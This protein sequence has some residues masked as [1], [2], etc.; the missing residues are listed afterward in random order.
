MNWKIGRNDPCPCGSGKKFKKCCGL[1]SDTALV[2]PFERYN[3][4]LTALKLKLDQHFSSSIKRL[5][6]D[7]M[8][9]FLHHTVNRTLPP[10]HEPLYSD[11]LWFDR[12]APEQ[13]S[14]AEQYLQENGPFMETPLRDCL[15]AL[16]DSSLSIYRVEDARDMLLEVSDLFSG[17][18]IEVL[19]KEPWQG[20]PDR[21]I[22]ILGRLVKVYED[23]LFS[24]M[25]LL[26]EDNAGQE[27]FLLAHY[28]YLQ[29]L[30]LFPDG[31]P[32]EVKYGLF[33]HAHKKKLFNLRDMRMTMID[34]DGIGL[35]MNRFA[36]Q[37]E[38]YLLHHTDQV[39]WYAPRQ[40]HYGYVRLVIG[41]DFVATAADVID[42]VNCLQAIITELTPQLKLDLIHSVFERRSP[43]PQAA[44]IWLTIMK[45]QQTEAWLDTCHRELDDQTPRQ[46]LAEAGGQERLLKLLGD[47]AQ[48]APSGDQ[49]EFIDFMKARVASF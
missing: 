38:L 22:L 17:Q 41:P 31:L 19:L 35:L 37:N 8:Q 2:D 44:D 1:W 18:R 11:W 10:E 15:Q 39:S 5:R 13:P 26:S 27:E 24:G 25:V 33:D 47:F 28:Q 30:N 45:D 43:S 3:Q 32:A 40:E 48:S 20:A 4:S 46:V 6:R 34:A 36:R 49:Q 12:L 16:S 9:L 21:S 7:N 14:L 29:E 23:R 42:D